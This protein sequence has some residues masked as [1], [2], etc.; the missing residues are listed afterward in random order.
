MAAVSVLLL[1]LGAFV[2]LCIHCCN[3]DYLL[4]LLFSSFFFWVHAMMGNLLS[5]KGKALCLTVFMFVY[6]QY[7]PLLLSRSGLSRGRYT[8]ETSDRTQ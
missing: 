6:H 4:I 5:H 2:F 7:S 8:S 1:I 3:E